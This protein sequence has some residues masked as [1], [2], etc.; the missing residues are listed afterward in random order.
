MPVLKVGLIGCGN[1]ARSVHLDILARLPGAELVA[2]AESDPHKRDEAC[3]RIPKAVCFADYNELLGMPGLEAVVICLPPALHAESAVAAFQSGKHVYLEKPVA[4]NLT[5]ARKV[6][7]VWRRSG[8]VGVIGYNYRFSPL[9][10]AAKKFIQS[11]RLGDLVGVRTVFS[12]AIRELPAWKRHRRDG[13]GVLLDLASHHIDLARFL[14]EKDIAEV[15][16]NLRSLCSEED[17][18]A[19]Q[20]RLAGG[21]LIQSFFSISASDEDRFEIYGQAG[22]LIIN[23]YAGDLEITEPFFEYGRPKQLQRELNALARGVRRVIRSQGEPSFRAA[24]SAFVFAV[25]NGRPSG[26]SL[27]DGYRSLIVIEAAEE[28]AGTGRVIS[29]PEKI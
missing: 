27:E 9:Y 24:L 26:P 19:L 15:S 6:L 7:E 10:Q 13:G 21:L 2:L 3:K 16:A 20:M 23:R 12:S 18:A 14:F 17:S 8:L 28:S 25:M 11:G 22:K 29:L 5:D 4:T 1:I